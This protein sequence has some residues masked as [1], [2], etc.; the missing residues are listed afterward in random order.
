MR[1]FI[2][3]SPSKTAQFTT[4]GSVSIQSDNYTTPKFELDN[5]ESAVI[6]YSESSAGFS[7]NLMVTKAI[8]FSKAALLIPNVESS[9]TLR[10]RL[11]FP[12]LSTQYGN[13]NLGPILI[14]MLNIN[15]NDGEFGDETYTFSANLT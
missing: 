9:I 6:I 2:S 5:F 11:K 13:I 3:S 8:I 12:E 14:L 4:K 10:F 15:K 7:F 1:S